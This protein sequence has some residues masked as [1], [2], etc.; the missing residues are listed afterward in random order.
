MSC[1]HEKQF[2][3]DVVISSF[4]L[5][6]DSRSQ[7]TGTF[8]KKQMHEILHSSFMVL[9]FKLLSRGVFTALQICIVAVFVTAILDY[10]SSDE[11]CLSEFLIRLMF[12]RL[13][14]FG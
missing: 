9:R 2:G 5:N 11:K 6:A 3:R 14:K 10:I 13:F 1:H 7:K 12:I 8:F 4:Y